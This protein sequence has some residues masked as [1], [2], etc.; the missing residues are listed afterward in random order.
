MPPAGTDRDCQDALNNG[1]D[2]LVIALD[3]ARAF[4]RV[5]HRVLLEELRA[6]GIEGNLLLLLADYLRGRI[7]RVVVNGQ[8]SRD[9]PIEVSVP[10]GSV[11]G[12][13][14]PVVS[15]YTNDCT[16][17]CSY[18]NQ[19]SQRAVQRV[20]QQLELIR[21]WGY[22]LADKALF[23]I[24]IPVVDVQRSFPH[25]KLDKIQRR[26]LRLM[27][28][29]LHPPHYIVTTVDSLEYRRDVA[30]LTVFH[31]DQV[32]EVPHL[33]GIRLPLRAMQRSTRTVLS[34]VQ[35]EE[36]LRSR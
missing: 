11:L 19:D 14:M 10:Q 33:E 34:S 9:F 8:T 24:L 5:W 36:A 20:N 18:P 15:A 28:S 1:L 17:L 35:L 12:Q 16:L 26:A 29:A 7:L 21:G 22:T 31:K 6:N 25:W 2:T 13:H 4:Y 32:Q 27:D 23:R 3:I 30:A